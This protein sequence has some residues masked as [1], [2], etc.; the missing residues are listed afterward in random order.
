M[1]QE[2]AHESTFLRLLFLKNPKQTSFIK[3]PLGWFFYVIILPM[4]NPIKDKIRSSLLKKRGLLTNHEQQSKSERIANNI[5]QSR[6]LAPAKKIALYHAVQKEADP[7]SLIDNK[8]LY[9][10]AQFYLPVLSSDKS[11]GLTFAPVNQNTQY[12]N[13][14]F[15]IPEPIVG[16]NEYISPEALDVVIMPLLGF[17][18][19]GNRLGMGGGYYDRCVAFKKSKPQKPTLIGF[20]YDFQQVDPLNKEPW[21]IGLDAIATE[22]RFINF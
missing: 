9:S 5:I 2:L 15:M 4:N 1:P 3:P 12:K 6:L 18:L 10:Q 21:D 22:S 17:D 13:N 20:A 19:S 7:A 14:Q 11:Q 8:D 16:L